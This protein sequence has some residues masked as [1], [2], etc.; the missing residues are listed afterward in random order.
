[1]T[2]AGAGGAA[3]SFLLVPSIIHGGEAVAAAR[4][5][6]EAAG[7]EQLRRR[8]RRG[9]RPMDGVALQAAHHLGAP[10]RRLPSHVSKRPRILLLLLLLEPHTGAHGEGEPCLVSPFATVFARLRL[11]RRLQFLRVRK[12]L[13]V[14]GKVQELPEGYHRTRC[15]N[16]VRDETQP[17]T[18]VVFSCMFFPSFFFLS[19]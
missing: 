1:M 2:R 5:G 16:S 12:G 4:R 15:C 9:V 11:T 10:R 8:R 17:C 3:V 7:D 6:E 14:L 13:P 19:F 18:L